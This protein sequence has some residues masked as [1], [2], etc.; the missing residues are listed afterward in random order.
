[1]T[2]IIDRL[3]CVNR[4]GA[5]QCKDDAHGRTSVRCK[6]NQ[7]VVQTLHHL[8]SKFIDLQVCSEIAETLSGLVQ[9]ILWD[10]GT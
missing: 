3:N 10:V 1:M 8:E 9:E 7:P 2:K 5:F 6:L 4:F